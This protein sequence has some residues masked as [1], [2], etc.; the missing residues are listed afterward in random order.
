MSDDDDDEEEEEE[1]EEDADAD[2][3]AD[4]D[5]ADDD[6]GVRSRCSSDSGINSFSAVVHSASLIA[7]VRGVAAAAAAAVVQTDKDCDR[8]GTEEG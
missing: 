6:D 8:V 7:M 2:A 4:D 1:E 3:D 5:D